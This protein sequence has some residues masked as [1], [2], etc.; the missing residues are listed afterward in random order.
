[1]PNFANESVYNLNKAILAKNYEQVVFLLTQLDAKNINDYD[2]K[3]RINKRRPIDCA[4]EIGDL[5]ILQLICGKH[6]I[7]DEPCES[8]GFNPIH[9][10]VRNLEGAQLKDVLTTLY[11]AGADFRAK[12]KLTG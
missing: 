4:V 9:L 5:I 11:Q 8:T 7:L 12:E 3:D 2:L 10:A 6:P 1:M